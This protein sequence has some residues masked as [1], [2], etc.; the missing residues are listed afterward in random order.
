MSHVVALIEWQEMGAFTVHA[1][2]WIEPMWLSIRGTTSL[3]G[4]NTV[5]RCPA[6]AKLGYNVSPPPVSVPNCHLEKKFPGP[7]KEIDYK[8][9]RHMQENVP[10]RI[11]TRPNNEHHVTPK[12]WHKEFTIC[13]RNA[14]RRADDSRNAAAEGVAS[15]RYR[16]AVVAL[17][18][19][20]FRV[21]G[22][23]FVVVGDE[24]V[25]ISYHRCVGIQLQL[26]HVIE[27]E[28]HYP[29]LHCPP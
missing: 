23:C 9:D 24:L 29:L 25:D 20:S 13:Y 22:T 27:H 4:M 10:K 21:F 14:E 17:T 3:E 15:D 12:Y 5:L 7:E 11:S 18:R 19:G 6:I 1:V 8:E 28:T 26:E 2:C 16:P